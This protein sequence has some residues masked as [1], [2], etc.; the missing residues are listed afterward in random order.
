MKSKTLLPLPVFDFAPAPNPSET[1]MMIRSLPPAT[2]AESMGIEVDEL[3]CYAR[4]RK[5]ITRM[6]YAF[7][8]C[9][10]GAELPAGF[11]EFAGMR[12]ER[13]RI[14]ARPNQHHSCGIRYDDLVHMEYLRTCGELAK[15]QANLIERLSK[16]R[17]FYRRQCSKDS[18]YGMPVGST[19][20]LASCGRGIGNACRSWSTD[21]ICRNRRVL[22]PASARKASRSASLSSLLLWIESS[23]S[24]TAKTLKSFL[25]STKSAD[26]WLIR[27]N[28]A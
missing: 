6:V 13:G 19:C 10:T 22:M 9:V 15:G 14:I 4:G 20:G 24:M 28:L 2:L 3:E 27:L 16:E 1:L 7:I 23:S 26:F 18:R 17:D 25:Q 21:G 8:R 11:G 5:K 12:I